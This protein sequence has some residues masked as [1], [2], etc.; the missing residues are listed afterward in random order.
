MQILYMRNTALEAVHG[1]K[2]PDLP[3]YFVETNHFIFVFTLISN[4]QLNTGFKNK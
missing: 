3:F 1:K 4:T 2:Q